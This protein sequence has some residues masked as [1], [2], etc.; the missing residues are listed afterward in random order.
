MA[1]VTMAFGDEVVDKRSRGHAPTAPHKT[2]AG[3]TVRGARDLK[4]KGYIDR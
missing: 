4:P 2:R 3:L 1:K